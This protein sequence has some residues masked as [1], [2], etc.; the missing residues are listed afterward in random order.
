MHFLE[1]GRPIVPDY[2]VL[3]TEVSGLG[4]EG[5][6]QALADQAMEAPNQFRDMSSSLLSRISSF[7]IKLK[8]TRIFFTSFSRYSLLAGRLFPA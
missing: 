5:I 1:R 3:S 4:G 2:H 8:A 7:K 6:A